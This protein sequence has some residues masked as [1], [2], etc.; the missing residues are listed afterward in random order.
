MDKDDIFIGLPYMFKMR[1]DE[2][3]AEV[4]RSSEYYDRLKNSSEHASK[5]LNKIQEDLNKINSDV[6][7]LFADIS[8]SAPRETGGD[9]SNK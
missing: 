3:K 8:N 2:L 9:K 7:E 6:N 5:N 4:S 1:Y